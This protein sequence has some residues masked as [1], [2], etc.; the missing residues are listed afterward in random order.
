MG[1]TLVC[2]NHLIQS[3]L[4]QSVSFPV[5]WGSNDKI[6][7]CSIKDQIS[8][9]GCSC[10]NLTS[11]D[12]EFGV[13]RVPCDDNVV[14]GISATHDRC[15][16]PCLSQSPVFSKQT[17]LRHQNRNS[18]S[19][20]PG[21]SSTGH[22]ISWKKVGHLR[23]CFQ[24][25]GQSVCVKKQE[26]T[27][28]KSEGICSYLCQKKKWCPACQAQVS[29][30]TPRCGLCKRLNLQNIC[31]CNDKWQ[32][33]TKRPKSR[34]VVETMNYL[35]T[36]IFWHQNLPEVPKVHILRDSIQRQSLTPDAWNQNWRI[37]SCSIQLGPITV[38]SFISSN[39]KY[40]NSALFNFVMKHKEK[41]NCKILLHGMAVLCC[42][43][44]K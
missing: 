43:A 9:S 4:P 44:G 7:I 39:G 22:K 42:A 5:V 3:K 8:C 25:W 12:E 6:I 31:F 13:H 29:P 28:D 32:M 30:R 18:S 15:C 33:P 27:C 23:K 40:M 10:L 14:P 34:C 36:N 41:Q 24:V 20:V 26:V 11:I 2:I 21:L 19:A 1:N 16:W 17:R 35:H 38:P 37:H